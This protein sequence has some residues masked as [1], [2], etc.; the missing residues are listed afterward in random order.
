MPAKL[1]G[2]ER[3][4]QRRERVKLLTANMTTYAYAMMGSALIDPVLKASGLRT[5]NL[6]MVAAAIAL[7]GLAA[8]LAPEGEKP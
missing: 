4:R 3:K 8:Y 5:A 1:V 2:K 6:V 7:H